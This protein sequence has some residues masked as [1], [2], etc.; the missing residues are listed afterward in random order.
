[1]IAG[2]PPLHFALDRKR[3][4]RGAR[5]VALDELYDGRIALHAQVPT[6]AGSW[7]DLL[8]ALCFATFP[9]SKRALHAR[10]ANAMAPRLPKAAARLPSARTSEQDALTL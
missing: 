9:A 6:R 7:H 5:K 8:N 2:L 3:R 10:Q 1:R 4:K